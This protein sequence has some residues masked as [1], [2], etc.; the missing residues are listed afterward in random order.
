MVRAKRLK[1][2]L[3]IDVTQHE[4]QLSWDSTFKQNK[5][6]EIILGWGA[7]LRKHILFSLVENTNVL[8]VNW[9]SLCQGNWNFIPIWSRDSVPLKL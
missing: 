3:L 8:S 1:G 5:V 6:L 4:G 2:D 9:I 7:C